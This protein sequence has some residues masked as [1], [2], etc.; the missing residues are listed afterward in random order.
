[1]AYEHQPGR[2]NMFRNE[3]AESN[4]KAP[5]WSGSIKIPEEAAGKTMDIAAWYNDAYTDKEGRSRKEKWSL[6]LSE[7]WDGGS[8]G[9]FSSD[10]RG[11]DTAPKDDIPF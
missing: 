2:G 1:M 9:S 6:S 8:K 3:R 11:P 4:P 7:P 5:L 10:A